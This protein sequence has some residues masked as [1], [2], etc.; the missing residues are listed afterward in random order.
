MAAKKLMALTPEQHAAMAPFAEEYTRRGLSTEPADRAR[1]ERGILASYKFAK[2]APPKCIVWVGSPAILVV[3]GPVAALT[4]ELRKQG[5]VGIAVGD[6]VRG[7]VRIAVDDAVDD[8]VGGAVDDAVDDAVRSSQGTRAE[9]DL[10]AAFLNAI[11]QGWYR[12]LGGRW[13]LGGWYWGVAYAA[14]FRDVVKLN[15]PGDT[16][17]RSHAY[18]D[19]M[20]AG[21]LWP[22]K[23][24]VMVCE[25]PVQLHMEAAPAPGQ[26]FPRLHAESGPAILWRDGTALWFMRG[27]RLTQQ[28]V[29]QPGT[30]TA[31]QIRAETNAEVR[32]AMID[33]FGAARY[34]RA[35]DA[36]VRHEDKDQ[37]GFARRLLVADIGDTEPLTMVEVVNSTPEPIGYV[38]EAEAAG[39]WVGSRWH[40]VYTLRVPPSMQTTGAALAW[41]F[42]LTGDAYAP[43]IET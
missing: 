8:A 19:M 14:F 23:D 21:W 26:R 18:A 37:Y 25:P 42:E 13:W 33:R 2:L 11:S 20:S 17:E 12:I 4:L 10:R 36:K 28:I 9:K 24:F 16:W 1:V 41:T 34:L 35:I 15:L 39:V 5:R 40:K 7:A 27:V 3:A 38:P 6:A 22:H 32:R 31:E 43:L 29:E 30:I